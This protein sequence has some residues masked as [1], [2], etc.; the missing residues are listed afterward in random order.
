MAKLLKFVALPAAILAS[1]VAAFAVLASLRTP[2]QRVERIH[3]GPLVETVDASPGVA[4]VT[5]RAQGTVRPDREID[6]VPQVSGAVVWVAESLEAGGFFAAGE[7]LARI[8]DEDYRLAVDQ[9]AAE[10]ARARYQLDLARGE[11]EVARDEWQRLGATKEDA[12]PSDLVLHIPQ[13]KVA[14][15]ALR[16]TEA[17]LREMQL[18]L[19]RTELTAPFAGRVRA[20]SLDLGQYVTP[21]RAVAR[22]YSTKR[23]EVSVP[24][25]DAELA[26]SEV[27]SPVARPSSQPRLGAMD[28]EGERRQP[29][30]PP[31]V[32]LTA[33]YAGRQH[34]W[35]GRVVRTEGEID[36][37]S[38]MV[39]VVVE[40]DDP[41]NDGPARTAPLMV[42]LFVDVEIA[43]RQL[44]AVRTIPRQA[45]HAD[46]TVWLLG[47]DGR[48]H[49]QAVEIV[50]VGREE[51]LVRFAAD[52]HAPV[53]TSQLKGVTEGMKVRVADRSNRSA[54]L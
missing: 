3:E 33:Q 39:N 43:G 20:T 24:V 14:E 41:Y 50:R 52:P 29:A 53:I 4:R 37:R 25:P 48:L 32:T 35:T 1:G 38:R 23:A 5:V 27:P 30:P 9:A 46:D 17:R 42:G 8:D 51:A 10:V 19:R 26:W 22:I 18:R 28:A 11:A 6:L 36:A 44:S 2:P 40:V 21:G 54:Q 15:S 13:V 16:A 12:A 34:H 47:T 7:V 45:L 31:E 49:M